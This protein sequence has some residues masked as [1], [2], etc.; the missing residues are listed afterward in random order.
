MQKTHGI[1]LWGMIAIFIVLGVVAY[2]VG[3]KVFGISRHDQIEAVRSDINNIRNGLT[4][5]KLDNGNYPST[6]QGLDALVSA[7]STS[8]EPR[9]WKEGGYIDALP[10]DPWGQDYQYVNNDGVIRVFS[11]GP[12]GKRGGS[13][14]DASNI[15]NQ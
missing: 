11:Y 13:E 8:P 14:I 5:Y 15:D 6:E 10:T 1:S 12:D 3:P 2:L 9:F 7:P 4:Q